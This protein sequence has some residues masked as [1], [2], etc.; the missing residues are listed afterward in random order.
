[1]R[2]NDYNVGNLLRQWRLA[3]GL[4]QQKVAD[5]LGLKTIT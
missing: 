5:A 2:N 1:M 4:D 3:K